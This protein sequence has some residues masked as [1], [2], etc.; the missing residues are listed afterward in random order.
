MPL[1]FDQQVVVEIHCPGESPGFFLSNNQRNPLF[2]I[3]VR[4]FLNLF[5]LFTTGLFFC[6]NDQN[7]DK[8]FHFILNFV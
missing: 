2:T 6:L 1:F 8:I 5:P 3:E 4:V 7:R